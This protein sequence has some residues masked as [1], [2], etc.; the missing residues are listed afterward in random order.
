MASFQNM[1]TLYSWPYYGRLVTSDIGYQIVHDTVLSYKNL[2][3]GQS[4]EEKDCIGLFVV[5]KIER[6][7]NRNHVDVCM[8]LLNIIYTFAFH[9]LM[10]VCQISKLR[11]NA[12]Y[13]CVCVGGC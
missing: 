1:L 4:V 11:F 5:I 12:L 8:E 6:Y 9:L 3:Y 7:F 13:V 2:N 10:V